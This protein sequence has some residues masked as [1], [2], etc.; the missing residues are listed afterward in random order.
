[1]P[2]TREAMKITPKDF[3]VQPGKKVK[4]AQWP[5]LVKPYYK[6]KAEYQEL[7]EKH[8]A[9]LST[10]QQASLCQRTAMPCC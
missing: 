5:T 1:M 8:K 7:L 6:S 2:S 4:L 10:L 9:Q 3:R